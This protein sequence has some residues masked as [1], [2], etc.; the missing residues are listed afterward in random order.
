MPEEFGHFPSAKQIIQYLNNYAD[1]FGLREMIQFNTRIQLVEP[2][3]VAEQE[4]WE[5]TLQNGEK[6]VYK[7]VVVANGHHWVS[8]G[9]CDL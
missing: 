3:W 9:Q 8:T 4:L 7:G 2:L 6:K 1:H 5:V